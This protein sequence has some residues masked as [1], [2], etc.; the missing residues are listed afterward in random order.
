MEPLR[1]NNSETHIG[2][3]VLIVRL[4]LGCLFLWSGIS[5]IQ[6][7]HEFLGNVYDYQMVGPVLGVLV[8]MILPWF[9]LVTGVCLLGGVLVAGM[10][11]ACMMM[12]CIFIVAI[13]WALH[14]DL[15]ISC[16]CFGDVNG[17]AI[18]YGT[19]ARA[20]LILAVS[21]LCYGLEV[22]GYPDIRTFYIGNRLSRHNAGALLERDDAPCPPSESG[23]RGSL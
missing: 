13:G 16:G 3:L 10:L 12:A 6:T 2:L 21:S 8:A 23:E 22:F 7:P 1:P 17:P 18:G 14:Y 20:F 15:N 9:E 19:L 4:A 5:K 11:L